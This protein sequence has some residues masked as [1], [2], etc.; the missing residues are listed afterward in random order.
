[1]SNNVV[2]FPQQEEPDIPSQSSGNGG[3]RN[4]VV[5]LRERVVGLET[6]VRH[7]ATKED[8]KALQAWILGRTVHIILAI[9][10]ATITITLAIVFA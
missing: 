9:I 2:H 10:G 6:E 5:Q 3:G 4:E 7:L 8:I 1:M